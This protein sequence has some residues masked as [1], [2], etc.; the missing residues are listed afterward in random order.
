MKMCYL[1]KLA[2]FV[3]AVLAASVSAQTAPT[4]IGWI[5]TGAFGDEKQGIVKYVAA[6]KTVDDGFKAQV[7]ELQSLRT[8]INAIVADLQKTPPANLANP[9]AVQAK[10]EEGERLQR[11]FEFKNK[12]FDAAYGKRRNE[13]VGAI[14]ADILK[15]VQEY[16]KQ[17]GFAVILDISTMAQGNALL[18]LDPSADITRDFVAFYNARGLGSAVPR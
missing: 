3:L 7:A 12:E 13:V 9:Q 14:S 6:I 17:K 16:G 1:P 8:R 18:H 2:A 11:E 10:R 4:R 5:R 15:A